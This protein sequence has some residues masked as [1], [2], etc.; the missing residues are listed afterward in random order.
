MQFNISEEEAK[1][2]KF[3]HEIF[4][5][6]LVFNHIL[7]LVALLSSREFAQYAFGV[8]IA[9]AFIIFFILI[10]AQRAKSKASWYVSGHWQLC[11]KRNLYFLIMIAIMGLIFLTLYIVSDGDLKPQHWALGGA[12]V[13]PT[14]VTVLILVIMESEALHHAKTGILP[15]WVKEKYPQ[16][17]LEPIID[18]NTQQGVE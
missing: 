7:V 14:M 18:N 6:N 15:D 9:S 5:I 13:L 17:S 8:P 10:G 2:A 11:A 4:L 3:P 1:K 12:A 16:G